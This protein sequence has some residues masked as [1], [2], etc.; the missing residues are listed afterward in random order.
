MDPIT[1]LVLAAIGGAYWYSRQ[2][3]PVGPI[4]ASAPPSPTSTQLKNIAVALASSSQFGSA[5]AASTAIT[6]VA[7]PPQDNFKNSIQSG[8]TAGAA[9]GAAFGPL[10]AA[11]GG[12]AGGFVAAFQASGGFSTGTSTSED[13]KIRELATN[14]GLDP[15]EF[16]AT[17]VGGK[18]FVWAV[19]TPAQKQFYLAAVH[20]ASNANMKIFTGVRTALNTVIAGHVTDA[21][22]S[23]VPLSIAVADFPPDTQAW[24]K[25]SEG[26]ATLT[27][28]YT[29]APGGIAQQR[30]AVASS[31]AFGQMILAARQAVTR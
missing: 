26:M 4:A 27:K 14:I 24:A 21:A 19:L 8:A 3:V 16:F 12:V 5:D 23:F 11:V 20:Q 29:S 25:T 6:Q 7:P 1:L 9:K 18:P 17:L 10:G 28:I 22:N 30:Q 15:D 13:P 31:Q 2:R